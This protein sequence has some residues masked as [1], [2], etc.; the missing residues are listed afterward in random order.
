MNFSVSY[1]TF[2]PYLFTAGFNLRLDQAYHP[3]V[4][5]YICGREGKNMYNLDE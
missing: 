3:S 1:Y 2:L 4:I 5:F